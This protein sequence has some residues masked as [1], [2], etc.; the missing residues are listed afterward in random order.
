MHLTVAFRVRSV[1]GLSGI[2]VGEPVVERLRTPE[3]HVD[4]VVGRQVADEAIGV[5]NRVVDHLRKLEAWHI[6]PREAW[7]VGSTTGRVASKLQRRHRLAG[8]VRR[9]CANDKCRS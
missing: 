2:E 5:G 1:W 6:R 4:R 7:V 9:C 3:S 8:V